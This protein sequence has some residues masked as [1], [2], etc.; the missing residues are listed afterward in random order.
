MHC[1]KASQRLRRLY[2]AHFLCQAK[3]H[4][5]RAQTAVGSFPKLASSCYESAK[6]KL[7]SFL[8]LEKTAGGFL[9]LA[10]GPR[11]KSATGA[12]MHV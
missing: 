10:P 8:N 2:I 7:L 1:G 4:I 12:A 6:S 3:T 5:P 11:D 9:A